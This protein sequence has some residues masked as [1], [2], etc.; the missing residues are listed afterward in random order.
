MNRRDFAKQ[1]SA[2][3]AASAV[4]G[5]ASEAPKAASSEMHMSEMHMSEMRMGAVAPNDSLSHMHDLVMEK[6]VTQLAPDAA[7][8]EKLTPRT[9]R[10]IAMLAYPD[11]VPLDLV[12]PH[13]ILSGLM[14]TTVDVVWKDKQPLMTASGITIVPSATLDE[15]P[16]N[17]DV[18]F[19]PGG[20]FGTVAMMK[21]ATILKF[22]AD[23]GARATY[24][25]SVCSGSL[26]LGAAG[27]LNGYRATT[28][29]AMQEV[30]PMLGATSVKE[31][32]VI[33][34]NRISA[35]GVSAG[36]DFALVLAGIMTGEP[37][38]KSL[39]LGI[40]YDP[41]PPFNAGSPAGAGPEL[42][43]LMT[44]MYEPLLSASKAAARR[45]G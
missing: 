11:M 6:M 39:Q 43:A 35:A 33:D 2:A 30:L 7:S 42:T 44:E 16:A 21:D 45:V 8:R 38:A 29:W 41:K 17:L 24:V 27:L 40:E 13:A 26:V 5:C 9:P 14:N 10:R 37:Y 25:C 32:V 20:G 31:R 19:V 18:L 1:I 23:R 28:H 15:V 22:L 36:I 4:T 34:R 3:L 12:G